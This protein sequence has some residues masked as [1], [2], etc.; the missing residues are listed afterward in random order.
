[1]A[2]IVS[3]DLQEENDGMYKILYYQKSLVVPSGIG[4]ESDAVQSVL[5]NKINVHFTNGALYQSLDTK[6][7]IEEDTAYWEL[8][9][10]SD[11]PTFSLTS[12]AC[13]LK[14]INDGNGDSIFN[15]TG[16]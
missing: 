14:V 10:N 6:K 8:V 3:L 5:A 12:G 13:F 9:A 1:M 11:T 7:A 15:I 4:N 2:N 16:V